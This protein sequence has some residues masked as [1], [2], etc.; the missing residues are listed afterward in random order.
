MSAPSGLT[1]EIVEELRADA[2]QLVAD[3]PDGSVGNKLALQ[4][5][6]LC[7]LAL[8]SLS[9]QAEP[10]V[11]IEKTKVVDTIT[12]LQALPTGEYEFFSRPCSP[13]GVAEGWKVSAH[14]DAEQCW[15]V[16]KGP[17]GQSAAFAVKT[18]IDEG[19][20]VS[21]RAQVLRDFISAAPVS[22]PEKQL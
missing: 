10:V 16:L 7:D 14:E 11:R 2:Q 18:L 6:A 19:H 21:I 9:A 15:L 13:G 20:A 1:K 5:V 4:E 17:A 22:P 12:W 8:A 3:W